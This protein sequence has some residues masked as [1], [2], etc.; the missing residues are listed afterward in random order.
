MSNCYR[1]QTLQANHH[2]LT[3]RVEL[4][5]LNVATI[6]RLVLIFIYLLILIASSSFSFTYWY[7]VIWIVAYIMYATIQITYNLQVM[8]LNHG[9]RYFSH[10]S[11][12]AFSPVHGIILQQFVLLIAFSP[13]HGIIL[14]QFVLLIAFSPVHGIILQQFVQLIA[15]SSPVHSIILQQFVLLIWS[16]AN[17]DIEVFKKHFTTIYHNT[18]PNKR[19]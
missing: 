6:N 11:A 16:A 9:H 15:F 5:S 8:D 1:R 17:N 3:R 12:S 7:Y 10:H 14:Q 2:T 19:F 18:Q 13:V 4:L